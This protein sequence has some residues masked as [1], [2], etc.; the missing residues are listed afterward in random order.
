MAE[1]LD[2]IND[3]EFFFFCHGIITQSN[4]IFLY[5]A[6]DDNTILKIT[7]LLS[8]KIKIR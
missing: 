4:I 3:L 2:L 8:K 5:I 1:K 6:S 7:S